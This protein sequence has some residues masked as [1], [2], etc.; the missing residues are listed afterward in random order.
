MRHLEPRTERD[1]HGGA[2]QRLLGS[3]AGY[4]LSRAHEP[5]RVDIVPDLAGYPELRLVD[6]WSALGPV[7]MIGLLLVFGGVDAALWGFGVATCALLHTTFTFDALAHGT[8]VD[9]TFHLLRGLERVG[10]VRGVRRAAL[11]AAEAP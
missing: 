7:A 11:D 10:L 4:C 2:A 8:D 9:A 3:H 1:V 5:T 6:R